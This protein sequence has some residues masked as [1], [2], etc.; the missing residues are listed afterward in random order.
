MV[1][2]CNTVY[3]SNTFLEKHFRIF[4]YELSDFQKH[5]IE[6]IVSGHHSLVCVPTGSGKTLP[7]EFAIQY[8]TNLGKKVIYCS[9]IKAL[10]NQKFYDFQRKYPHLQIG[11]FTGDIKINPT[12]DV[13]IMTTEIL[14]NAL[15]RKCNDENKET[16]NLLTRTLDFQLDFDTELA[17]VVFDEVH[18]INDADRGHVWEK[19][20]MLLGKTVQMIML[21]ATID[22]PEGFAS[23]I[24]SS[25]QDEKSVYLSFNN[26]RIVPLTHYGFLATNESPFKNIK[27]KAIQKEIRDATNKL[28]PLRLPKGEFVDQGYNQ[29]KKI[30]TIFNTNRLYMKRKFVLNKLLEQLVIDEML[31]AICFVFSRKHVEL[32]A[33]EITVNLLEFDSKVPYTMR[34][35]CEQ[36]VRKFPN[37]AE[38]LGLPEYNDLVSLLEK[39]IGIH[40]SGMITVLREIV[41]IMIGRKSIKIL[42]ATESFS[43]GLDCPI[44]TAIFSSLTKYDNAGQRSLYSHEYMQCAGRAGRRGIDTVGHV[45]HCNNLFQTPSVNA[46][47]DILCGTNQKLVS[48]FGISY[49]IILNLLSNEMTTMDEFYP[50]I[51]KSMMAGEIEKQ[52]HTQLRIVTDIEE[53]LQKKIDCSAQVSK[54]DESILRKYVELEANIGLYNAKKRKEAERE[55]VA[56][57]ECEK[58][59]KQDLERWKEIAVL[60][61]D[62][63]C[64]Q[65]H[66]DY[67]SSFI[68]DK[69]LE[70]CQKLVTF[71]FVIQK[72]THN[73][74]YEFTRLV[75]MASGL[76]EVPEL[77][78]AK[79]LEEF[80]F[81][82]E[83]DTPALI[84]LFS[85]FTDVKIAEE[86]KVFRLENHFLT[87]KLTLVREWFALFY[88]EIDDLDKCIQV[89]L[90]ECVTGWLNA[91]SEEECKIFIQTTLSEKGISIGDFT[92]AIL[93][94]TAI[95]NEFSRIC[96][97]EQEIECLHKLAQIEGMLLKYVA[98]AQSLYI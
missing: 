5:S 46:Y 28:I 98:T 26:H 55:M 73:L 20:I 62:L 67:L 33:K 10:S 93:K 56:I 66:M 31:P 65:K 71:G 38:Y 3:P 54:T 43:I 52:L 4:P 77:I 13:L 29:I 1:K 42:F 72:E 49:K 47:K 34:R 75:R 86:S 19:S 91:H 8:F 21:S 9:P 27:D 11:L 16:S 7:A 53:R 48:K 82:S 37:Y 17:A 90:V 59:F 15:F 64:E 60:R 70:I 97:Q 39:G 50:F 84:Q 88:P 35:E 78:G 44:R 6:A 18:Y 36:I 96:E 79:M 30:E 69:L 74:Q 45:I 2:I 24:E 51:K 92:K 87:P 76:A 61:K 80:R 85:C 58:T 12:A 23:W 14:M 40:H 32:A 22:N 25:R 57:S 41:E 63:S 94:I 68:Y 95:S 89:D 81:F 83:F